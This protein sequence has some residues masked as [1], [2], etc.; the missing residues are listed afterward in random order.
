MSAGKELCTLTRLKEQEIAPEL[1]MGATNAV[2]RE[3]RG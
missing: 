2:E 1:G 3:F